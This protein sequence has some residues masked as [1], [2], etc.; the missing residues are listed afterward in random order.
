MVLDFQVSQNLYHSYEINEMV[1]SNGMR[2]ISLGPD[3]ADRLQR[4]AIYP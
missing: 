4:Y 1:L 3:F 2:D